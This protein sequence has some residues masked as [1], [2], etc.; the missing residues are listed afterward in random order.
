M[1][2]LYINSPMDIQ[3]SSNKLVSLTVLK[4]FGYY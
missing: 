3:V 4:D 2:Y 1:T